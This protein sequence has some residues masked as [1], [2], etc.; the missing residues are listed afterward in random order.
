MGT[1]TVLYSGADLAQMDVALIGLAMTVMGEHSV[2]QKQPAPTVLHMMI[3]T[4]THTHTH[5]PVQ[6]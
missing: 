1:G 3:H 5:L 6:L 4:H 2:L